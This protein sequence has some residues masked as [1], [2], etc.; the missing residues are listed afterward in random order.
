MVTVIYL[1]VFLVISY[2]YDDDRMLVIIVFR[3]SLKAK[4]YVDQELKQSDPKF[5]LQNQNDYK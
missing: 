3:S 2:V 5:S 1:L 4:K